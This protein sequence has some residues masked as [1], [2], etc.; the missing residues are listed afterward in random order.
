M[1]RSLVAAAAALIASVA[2]PARA[3]TTKQW[4]F[5]T[6]DAVQVNNNSSLTFRG[7]LSGDSGPTDH[8][9]SFYSS[10]TPQ[11]EM[12]QRFALLAMSKPGQYVLFVDA[13]YTTPICKLSRAVP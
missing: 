8:I 6:V 11:F 3:Q 1:K 13:T 2:A 12:C 7:V 10:T 4:T 5:T 9:V